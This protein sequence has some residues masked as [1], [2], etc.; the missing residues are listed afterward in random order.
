MSPT[1]LKHFCLRDINVHIFLPQII[2]CIT[3]SVG[4]AALLT[5]IHNSTKNYYFWAFK[6]ALQLWSSGLLFILPQ[7]CWKIHLLHHFSHLLPQPS[8]FWKLQVENVALRF[9][10]QQRLLLEPTRAGTIATPPLPSGP[11]GW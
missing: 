9:S 8:V 6:L 4:D 11:Q 3:S 5:R 10:F 1:F 2:L 7:E